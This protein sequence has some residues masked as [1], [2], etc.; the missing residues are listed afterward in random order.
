MHKIVLKLL[1]IFILLFLL[2]CQDNIKPIDKYFLRFSN[3]LNDNEIL[4][5]KNLD[6]DSITSYTQHRLSRP[7][8]K[9]I[10]ED[11]SFLELDSILISKGVTKNR[12]KVNT[13]IIAFQHKLNNKEIDYKRI[14]ERV[15]SFWIQYDLD[16]KEFNRKYTEERSNIA[17]TNYVN[18][19]K[20][21]SV[22]LVFP[23]SLIEEGY[24]LRSAIY[25]GDYQLE[26]E[27]TLLVYGA[28]IDKFYFVDTLNYSN[29]KYGT[30]FLKIRIIALNKE[31]PLIL[32]NEYTINDLLTVELNEYGR[33]INKYTLKDARDYGFY[34]IDTI[35][36]TK[37]DLRIKK[38]FLELIQENR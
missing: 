33:Q 13:F 21:D 36:L 16:E 7:F 35:K 28:V 12:C 1:Y 38:S 37:D 20:N 10:R 23:Y 17:Q 30:Y 22:G 15:D 3:T 34:N 24:N 2:G 4:A 32:M 27:D 8:L 26:F 31:K 11:S 25:K 9:E 18:L 29:T 6:K 5:L 14:A 19:S